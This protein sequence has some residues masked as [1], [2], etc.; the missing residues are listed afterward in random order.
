MPNCLSRRA[1]LFVGFLIS[2]LWASTDVCAVDALLWYGS[3]ALI[4]GVHTLRLC[5]KLL[6]PALS[7]ELMELYVRVFK[8]LKVSRKHFR[9]LTREAV[10]VE[11]SPGQRYAV[12]EVTTC[13]ERLSI[14]LRGRWVIKYII[15]IIKIQNTYN[16]H[17]VYQISARI[18][19]GNYFGRGVWKYF[20]LYFCVHESY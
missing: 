12:E 9:E 14:L 10:I 6:P 7:V 17:I 3:L 2:G 11:M 1:L 18:N 15:Y 19:T 16:L 13:N 8:P 4:N 20:K 5:K